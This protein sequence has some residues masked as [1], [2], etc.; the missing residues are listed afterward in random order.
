MFCVYRGVCL[1]P[2]FTHSMFT[3]C[4]HFHQEY[5]AS[6]YC[7]IVRYT[8]FALSILSVDMHSISDDLLHLIFIQLKLCKPMHTVIQ[9]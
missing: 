2:A 7:N 5:L 1:N 9:I 3:I 8:S 4:L 6:M